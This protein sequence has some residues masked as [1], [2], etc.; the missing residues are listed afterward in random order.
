MILNKISES[1]R[2]NLAMSVIVTFSIAFVLFWI[3]WNFGRSFAQ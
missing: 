1:F 3:G 2:S